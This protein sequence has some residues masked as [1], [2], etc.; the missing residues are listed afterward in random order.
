[1]EL[2]RK[3]IDICLARRKM[4]IGQLAEECGFSRNRLNVLLNSRNITPASAGKV[5]GGLGVDI[6]EIIEAEK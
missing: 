2:N 1:M 5:A 4:T 6:T 3:K